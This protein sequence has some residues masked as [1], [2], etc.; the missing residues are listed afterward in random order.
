MVRKLVSL[1]L[2]LVLA[3]VGAA[4]VSAKTKAEKE[5]QRAEKVRQA[6]A[7][8]G[9]GEQA[10]VKVKLHDGTKLAGYVSAAEGETFTVTHPKSGAATVVPY[11]QVGQV[12]GNNL[13]TGAKIAIGVGVAVLIVAILWAVADKDFTN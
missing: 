10:L 3:H 1:T 13:S 9:T 6:V 8:L 5:A 7:R 12:K 4:A 2:A 11:R